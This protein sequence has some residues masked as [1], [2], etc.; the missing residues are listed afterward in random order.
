[1][2]AR[3][4]T[5]REITAAAVEK[6]MEGMLATEHKRAALASV[7]T[8]AEE[9][10]NERRKWQVAERIRKLGTEKPNIL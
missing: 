4:D 6:Q 9:I 3:I 2:Y 7:E 5:A 1:L 8:G 10:E